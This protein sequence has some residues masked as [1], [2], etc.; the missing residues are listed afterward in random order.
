MVQRRLAGCVRWG[1]LCP[2]RC[3]QAGLQVPISQR[4]PHATLAPCQAGSTV[5][6]RGGGKNRES[7]A[8]AISPSQILWEISKVWSINCATVLCNYS[9]NCIAAILSCPCPLWVKSRHQGLPARCPLYPQKR[10]SELSRRMSALCQKQ[11]LCGAAK[12]RLLDHVV[13]AF[14]PQHLSV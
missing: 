3:L 14:E 10:T 5:W 13:E 12:F 8:N 7:R 1:R 6:R 9:K 4:I 11:T 2:V